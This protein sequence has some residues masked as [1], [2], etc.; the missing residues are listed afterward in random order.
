MLY[1]YDAE[2]LWSWL[3]ALGDDSKNVAEVLPITAQN[4]ERAL[5]LQV[6]KHLSKADAD[7]IKAK[8]DR[9]VAWLPEC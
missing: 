1:D 6:T 2:N 5:A 7:A 3:D 4:I 8:W 9:M